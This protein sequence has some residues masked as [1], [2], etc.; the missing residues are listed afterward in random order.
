MT[1]VFSK[2][3]I[4]KME[5]RADE[6]R[7]E[8]LP[9]ERLLNVIGNRDARFELLV[10]AARDAGFNVSVTVTSCTMDS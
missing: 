6:L 3:Q 10:S 8:L 9:L 5:K 1:Q 2:D 7:A 4:K